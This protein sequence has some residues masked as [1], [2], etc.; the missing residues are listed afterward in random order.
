MEAYCRDIAAGIVHFM[1]RQVT[2]TARNVYTAIRRTFLRVLWT[3]GHRKVI[4][5]APILD[6]QPMPI[7]GQC[8]R[9]Q[10]CRLST[11][12][13]YANTEIAYVG[14]HC[15]VLSNSDYDLEQQYN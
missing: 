5:F 4:V 12:I 3:C 10:V 7:S 8:D 11:G 13:L 14:Q 6:M 1:E 2:A 15:K 9:N